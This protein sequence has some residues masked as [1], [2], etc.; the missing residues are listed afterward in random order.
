MQLQ[1]VPTS[2]RLLSATARHHLGVHREGRAMKEF[3]VEITTTIPR[4]H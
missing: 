3:L 2:A 1:Q 4:G